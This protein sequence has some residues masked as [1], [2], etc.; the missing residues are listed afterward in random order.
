MNPA[1]LG[2]LIVL[3]IGYDPQVPI[4]PANHPTMAVGGPPPDPAATALALRMQARSPRSTLSSMSSYG[5]VDRRKSASVNAMITLVVA[6]LAVLG[7]TD[8]ADIET[9]QVRPWGCRTCSI[10]VPQKPPGPPVDS[11]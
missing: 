9:D 10:P 6:L 8:A 11:L 5:W 1:L 2:A 3:A 4:R 7:A